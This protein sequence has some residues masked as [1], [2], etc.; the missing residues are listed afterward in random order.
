M[1]TT[2]KG[3]YLFV[4]LFIINLI[5]FFFIGESPLTMFLVSSFYLLLALLT[6]CTTLYM[7]YLL[8]D[9]MTSITPNAISPL[10]STAYFLI[11]LYNVY[12]VIYFLNKITAFIDVNESGTHGKWGATKRYLLGIILS[13]AILSLYYLISEFNPDYAVLALIVAAILLLRVLRNKAGILWVGFTTSASLVLCLVTELDVPFF[14]LFF[15]MFIVFLHAS[16]VW[17]YKRYR[18]IE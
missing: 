2:L 17:F 13:C 11:P 18:F 15:I 7:L 10:R 12:W 3:L 14:C 5:W 6:I 16:S 4:S 9:G 8:W 1:P